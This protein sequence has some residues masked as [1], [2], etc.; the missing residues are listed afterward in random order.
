K[1]RAEVILTELLP[2]MQEL[3]HTR[4][5][6]G[7]WM[8]QKRVLPSLATIGTSARIRREARGTCLIIAP[9]NYPFSLAVGPLVSALAAGNSAIVKPS[10]MTP[11][12]SSVIARVIAEAFP[13]DLVTVIEGGVKTSETLLALPFDHIFFTGSPRVGQIVMAAASKTLASVTLE[14]G[15]K[16]P[17]IVGPGADLARAA[18]WIAFGKFANAGQTCI[19]PDH[20][21]VQS[22]VKDRF[23]QALRDRIT[24]AY[25]SGLDSPHL[26][27]IVTDKHARRLQDLLSDALQKGAQLTHGGQAEGRR[28]APTIIEALTPEMDI[29]DEEIFG[30]ILPVMVYDDIVEVIDRIN[31]RPK[32]LALYIF[33]RDRTL[34]E[35]VIGATSSGSV[36]INLTMAQFSHPALPFGGVNWSGIGAAHGE[37][38][39]LAFSHERAILANKG[40]LLPLVFPPYTPKV[41]Q[42]VGWIKR[43]MG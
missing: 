26:A 30:P 15:G 39:F 5:H 42:L 14:L 13:P 17:T 21:F 25:G 43:L 22:S 31:D 40:T 10:E 24:R 1:P 18:D 7:R 28:M 20:V 38:G 11:A 12:S 27:Q 37:Y 32:P 9:W 3:R 35:Q 41:M 29:Q 8:R 23:L 2:V 6:V 19:A 16:S 33:D 4:R 36:G 34:A